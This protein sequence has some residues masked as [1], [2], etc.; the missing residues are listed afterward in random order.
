MTHYS[1]QATDQISVKGYEFLHFA[2]NMSTNISEHINSKYSQDILDH[3]K[4]SA[5]DAFKTASKRAI[6]IIDDLRLI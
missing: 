6:Q 3:T 4:Q 5:T 1:V 2:R